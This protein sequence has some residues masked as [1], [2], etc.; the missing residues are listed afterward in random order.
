MTINKTTLS[1]LNAIKRK[2]AQS[3]PD[4]PT[5]QGMSAEQIKNTFWKFV[6]DNEDSIIEELN[7]IVDETNNNLN[8]LND[9]LSKQLTDGLFAKLNKSQG[10]DNANKTMI[11]DADGNV[12]PSDV[13]YTQQINIGS[14]VIT[15]IT[16]DTGESGIRLS[17]PETGGNG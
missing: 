10:S 14:V 1:K 7:R 5:N 13:V 11:T 2:S 6:L 17:I 15:P 16:T 4:N 8:E 9:N 12:K 3:L